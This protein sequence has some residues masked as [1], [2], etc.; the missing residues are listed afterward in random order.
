MYCA[1]TMHVHERRGTD[2]SYDNFQRNRTE[3]FS[4]WF[5]L[6]SEGE[7]NVK[8][9]RQRL[10]WQA[11][12]VPII[13]SLGSHSAVN[14]WHFCS[15]ANLR[16]R[17]PSVNAPRA[18]E[19]EAPFRFLTLRLYFFTFRFFRTVYSLSLTFSTLRLVTSRVICQGY[20]INWQVNTRALACTLKQL[21][22]QQS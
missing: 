10:L 8:H 14:Q 12:A 4:S 20:K 17:S 3:V 21:H 11:I 1:C 22:L 19:P 5:P 18:P 6:S 15:C 9:E 7:K 16:K 2:E 13:D